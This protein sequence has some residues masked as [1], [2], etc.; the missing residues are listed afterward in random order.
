MLSV[1]LRLL[2]PVQWDILCFCCDH[3]LWDV[4]TSLATMTKIACFQS[5]WMHKK[6][7]KELL[8]EWAKASSGRP[9]L[10]KLGPF[11][12]LWGLFGCC[13]HSGSWRNDTGLENSTILLLWLCTLCHNTFLVSEIHHYSLFAILL[14]GVWIYDSKIQCPWKSLRKSVCIDAH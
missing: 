11:Q 3:K 4:C 7:A 6:A 14:G 12:S 8:E 9:L 13:D 2:V 1:S 5:S 10:V